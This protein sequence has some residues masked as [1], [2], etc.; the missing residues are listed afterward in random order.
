MSA[1][2]AVP[3]PIMELEIEGERIEVEPRPEVAATLFGDRLG[4]AQAYAN[5]LVR[6]GELLGLL[7]PLEYPRLWTRHI[8]NS[9]LIAPL[10]AGKVGDVGSGAG[11][12]GIPLAIARPDVEFTLIEPMERRHS[13][14]V[15]QIEELGLE[16]VTA[17]RARAEEI[18][19]SSA[20]DQVT[21]RA[22]AALSKLLPWTV[23][24]VRYGGEIVLLKGRSAEAEIAKAQ[25]VIRRFKLEDVRVEEVGEDLDTEPTR[26]VRATVE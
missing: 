25:K 15:Q 23:P 9:A 7:G 22:V 21:A 8:V 14:L 2:Q 10:L 24:L 3:E 13:W 5:A 18:E 1:A 17:V 20:F 19:D 6:D 16:N 12:P 26:V 4:I 11:L